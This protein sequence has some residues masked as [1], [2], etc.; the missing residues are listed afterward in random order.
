[1]SRLLAVVDDDEAV[2]EA[3]VW[4][5]ESNGL[6]VQPEALLQDDAAQFACLILDMRLSGMS[7]L[8]LFERLLQRPYCPPAIFLTGHADVPLA[9]S[10]LKMGAFD[11]VEKPFDDLLLLTRVQQAIS[12]DQQNRQQ[13]SQQQ[14]ILGALNQLTDREQEVMQLVLAGK[15]NKQIA[16]SL[17][18]SIKTVEVHR[19]R[20]MEKMGVKS[21]V[22]LAGLLAQYRPHAAKS[23]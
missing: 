5:L 8:M 17:D 21:A 4:L 3:L 13:Q 15:L 20:V 1:M 6:A 18:I 16:D 9:V 22:E 10:A 2:R 11:F 23:D 7:G 12:Q 19:A 14:R